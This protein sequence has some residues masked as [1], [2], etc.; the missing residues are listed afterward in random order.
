[1]LNNG[2]LT[3]ARVTIS[4]PES[5]KEFIDAQN[6]MKGYGDL[7]EYFRDLLSD[8]RVKQS[9]AQLESLLPQGLASERVPF[10]DAFRASL[11]AD[12][13]QILDNHKDHASA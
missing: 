12:S 8:A 2:N 11:A 1:M 10:D 6:A 4:L 7:S 9:D 13:E 3:M 5:F